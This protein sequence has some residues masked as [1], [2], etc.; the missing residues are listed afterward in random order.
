VIPLLI[1]IAILGG[2]LAWELW[3]SEGAHLGR[4]FVVALYD[5][6]AGRYDRIKQFDMDWEAQFLGRPLANLLREYPNPRLLDVGAGTGRTARALRHAGQLANGSVSSAKP[7]A[8]A[9]REPSPGMLIGLEPSRRMIKLGRE[10]AGPGFWWI[11]GWAV[12][13][14]FG[15]GSFDIVICLEVL[16]FT[17]DPKRTLTEIL[18]VLRPGGWLLTSNRIGW[19]APLIFGRTFSPKRFPRVLQELGFAGVEQHAWQV[20]YDIAW[21]QKPWA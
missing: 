15:S 8:T 21:A 1:G 10:R 13:L 6:A 16:E 7:S 12:P 9:K 3:I 18:R 20:D 5:L 17:P 14:P 19:Q 11:R 2:L 4:R